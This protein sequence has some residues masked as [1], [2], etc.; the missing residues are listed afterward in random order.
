MAIFNTVYGGEKWEPWTNTIAYYP[1]TSTTTV[2]DM[3]G[4]NRNL[5][6]NWTQ[7]W[8][9]AGVSC[10][11]LSNWESK[12]LYSTIPL[13]WNTNFTICAYVN[14]IGTSSVD[15]SQ[16]FIIWNVWTNSKC[17]WLT[18]RTSNSQYWAWSWGLADITSTSTNTMNNWEMV[19]LT[20]NWNTVTVYKNWS[21]ISSGSLATNITS[22]D[23]TIWSF[24]QISYWNYQSFNGYMSEF[25]VEDKVRTAQEIAD[26]YKKTKVKYWL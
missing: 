20:K 11:Y 2:N 18:I 7:F 21:Q 6:N 16:I 15:G 10:A 8:T 26:Y 13:T 9:Y 1:L 5:T 22:T 12:K 3:S 4:N 25:I 14:R 24:N 19:T 23:F 17:L